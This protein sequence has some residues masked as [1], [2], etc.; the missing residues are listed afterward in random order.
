MALTE[1]QIIELSS[2]LNNDPLVMG[3]PVFETKKSLDLLNDSD[4]NI[5]G[6]TVAKTLTVGLLHESLVVDDFSGNQ[7]TDGERRYLESFLSRDF[8]VEIDQHKEKIRNT[9]KTNST[10]V[11]NIDALARP[12]SRGEVLFGVD[13]VI[14]K[15]EFIAARDL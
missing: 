7:V 10:T 5:G 11:A 15:A 12:L 9:F 13:I 1:I 8:D 3:Y 14:S 6:E 4:K 2:E